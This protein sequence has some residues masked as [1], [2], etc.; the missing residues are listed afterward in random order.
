M[1]K[2]NHLTSALQ[3]SKIVFFHTFFIIWAG[4][5]LVAAPGRTAYFPAKVFK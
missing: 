5:H 1:G 3:I 2:I 4:A